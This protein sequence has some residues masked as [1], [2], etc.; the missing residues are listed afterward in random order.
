MSDS[1]VTIAAYAD[2]LEARSALALLHEAGVASFLTGEMTAVTFF[3]NSGMGPHI[4][5]LVARSDSK[6]AADILSSRDEK[7]AMPAGWEDDFPAEEGYWICSLCDEAVEDH[8][9]LC[10]SCESP[11]PDPDAADSP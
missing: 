11:R 1:F 6:R 10:P 4:Q 3:G 2:S 9:D 5:L 8:A 7:P